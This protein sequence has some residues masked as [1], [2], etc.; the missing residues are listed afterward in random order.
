MSP[1]AR[2]WCSGASGCAARAASGLVAFGAGAPRVLPP[3][4]SK[5]GMVALRRVL[6]EGV[7]P[8][9]RQDP[10]A[11]ADALRRAGRLAGQPGLVVGDL[12]LPRSAAR[13]SGRSGR[14]ACATPCS[15]SR[16]STPA[17]PSCPRSGIWR[18]SIPRPASG[19]RSTPPAAAFAS[20]SPSS[21][22]SRREPVAGE[23]RRLRVHHTTLSTDGDWLVDAGASTA[24]SFGA[25]LWL[26][27]L[28]LVPL[29]LAA[30]IRC[31]PARQA[32]RDPLHRGLD[33]CARRSRRRPPGSAI[34]RPRSR[35][36]RR[37]CSPSPWP[38]RT[39]PTACPT[40]QASLML[41][42]DHSG[43][44][45][46]ND[47][48]PTPAGGSGVR[49]QHLHRPAARAPSASAR[50]ASRPHPTRCR[51]RSP[52]TPRP[53][54]SSTPSPPAGGTDTGDALGARAPAPARRRREASAGGDRAAV[55]RRG[56]RRA[57]PG[58]RGRQA[59]PRPDPDLHGRAGDARRGAD[60][61]DPLAA[62]VSVPPDPQLMQQIA[63][64]SG[65]R[66]FNAQSADELSS[67]YKR[68]GSQLGRSA[69]SG[70][71]RSCSRSPGWWRCW[72]PRP[73]RCAGPGACR[74]E[75]RAPTSAPDIRSYPIMGQ[76]RML[77]HPCSRPA[78]FRA[79]TSRS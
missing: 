43:S 40:N 1:R 76:C 52:T 15:R 10:E 28:A 73:D 51:D 63:Q 6:A 53:A 25:P 79:Q 42:T 70:R 24:M 26:L 19:S 30:Y 7:A 27:A 23:L 34:S 41:V 60:N 47:V 46:A 50:S 64:V 36:P 29:A 44:M 75:L 18:W 38:A 32:L 16:S 2:R 55:R 59:A 17:R 13:G 77:S 72:E 74:D 48:Q 37:R 4:G 61:P 69:A 71:S 54:R 78:R 14:C 22:A 57:G 8:D 9:G 68:L 66:A 62:A 11:L 20:G 5:P 67:I 39:S 58:H 21:S 12:R 56:Q 65:A 3:R 33:A 45:A 35:W 31:A 49:R